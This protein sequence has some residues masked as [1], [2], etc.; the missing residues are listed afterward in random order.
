M[1]IVCLGLAYSGSQPFIYYKQMAG[2]SAVYCSCQLA[3]SIYLSLHKMHIE[4]HLGLN[5]H[6]KINNTGSDHY[7]IFCSS[8]GVYSTCFTFVNSCTS[9]LKG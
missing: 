2:L 3:I 5:F 8:D 1:Y 6:G 9:T 4:L 7:F